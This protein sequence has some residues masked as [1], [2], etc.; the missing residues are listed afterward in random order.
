MQVIGIFSLFF[1]LFLLCFM[2]IFVHQEWTREDLGV[3]WAVAGVKV[4]FVLWFH[5]QSF[6]SPSKAEPELS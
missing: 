3:A 2:D 4:Q 1:F 5:G 6:P